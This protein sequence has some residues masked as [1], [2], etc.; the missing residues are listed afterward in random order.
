M[1]L[2]ASGFQL[3][4]AGTLHDYQDL[5]SFVAFLADGIRPACD[6]LSFAVLSSFA[7][8]VTSRHFTSTIH[9]LLGLCISRYPEYDGLLDNPGRHS[10]HITFPWSSTCICAVGRAG[11]F[12]FRHVGLLLLC[13]FRHLADTGSVEDSWYGSVSRTLGQRYRFVGEQTPHVLGVEAFFP[14]YCVFSLIGVPR[15]DHHMEDWNHINTPV[16]RLFFSFF[17]RQVVIQDACG[18]IPRRSSGTAVFRSR[19]CWVWG[20][21]ES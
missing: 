19:F 9:Y 10:T 14:F 3:R 6:S 5:I 4:T 2:R 1:T 17:P 21:E 20:A 7:A 13:F 16:L 11:W 8:Y 12:A 15:R 18:F